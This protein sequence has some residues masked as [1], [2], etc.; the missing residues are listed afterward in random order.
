MEQ[1][2]R[3]RFLQ[4]SVA[5]GAGATLMVFADGSYQIALAQEKP[6]FRLRVLHTNDHHARIEPV[7][8]SDNA[9]IHAGVSRRK[10]LLDSIRKENAT[11][12]LLLDAGDVF[13]GTLYFNLYN[14]QADLEFY[15]AMG[16]DAVA[17]GN[18]EFDK[19]QQILADYIKRAK[20]PVMSANI[21]T[22]A[23]SPLRGLIT[24]HLIINRAGKKI[25][26]FGLTTEDT[27]VLSNP[28]PGVVFSPALAAAP[29]QVKVLR[30]AGA[31]YVIALTHIGYQNDLKLAE[32]VAGINLV[33]GGHSHTP[34]A[35][36]NNVTG[37]A[38]PTVVYGPDGSPVIVT[39]DWEWGRWLG[40]LTL[41]FNSA[42]QVINV[43]GKPTE[44]AASLAADAGFERR[45]AVF[46]APLEELRARRVGETRS[47]LNGRRA[48]VRSKETNLGDL[49]ADAMLQKAAGSGAQIAI[50]NGGGI[51]AS[52]PAGPVTVGQILEVLPFGNTLALVDISGAL[53]K[54][55]L[56]NGVSQVESGAGRFPQV[57]GIRFRF[58]RTKPVGERVTSILF[59]DAPID[60]AATYKVVTNNF[61]LTGGDGYSAFTRGSG[62]YDSGFI[63]A[64]VVEE[65]IAANSPLDYQVDGRIAEGA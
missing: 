4:Q 22:A 65:F 46:K 48:D 35:P 31:D 27:A 2:S 17:I 39:T 20:F 55:A 10:A 8:G 60:P 51:R 52:I 11:P 62:G 42:G 33:V 44:V 26:I 28:G 18:H 25:G 7:L 15:N 29:A 58:D 38:Y 24:P 12:L 56:E 1:I 57:S 45:I 53:V 50:T 23:S 19:T 37:P 59:N 32:T 5:V 36:M 41:S 47:E 64:D 16:Y 54:Q 14:G 63:L 40:D 61:M 9:P 49:I 34:L 6:A 21:L 3:R 30:D 13:Q 43:E